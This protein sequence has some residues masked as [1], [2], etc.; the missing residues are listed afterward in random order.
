MVAVK[1]S[2]RLRSH[3]CLLLLLVCRINH[4]NMRLFAVAIYWW[5]MA[6]PVMDKPCKSS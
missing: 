1:K 3:K 6:R 4:Q 2:D 5:W